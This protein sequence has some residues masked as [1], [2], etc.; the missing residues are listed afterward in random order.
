MKFLKT[1]LLATA[2]LFALAATAQNQPQKPQTKGQMNSQKLATTLYLIENF[3][4]DTAN[5]DKVTEN[6][7]VAA[8]KELDPH[9]A[10]ISKKDVEK[11]NE[12]LVGSFEGRPRW[13]W[14]AGHRSRTCP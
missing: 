12:P 5:I 10:Y 6:A 1:F 11:A 4:V 2:C 9:S 7:I 8:L 13:R 3:Y 14:L